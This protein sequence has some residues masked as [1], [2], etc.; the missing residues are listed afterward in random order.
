MS[1]NEELDF[2]LGAIVLA[3]VPF[4]MD[5]QYFAPETRSW[6]LVTRDQVCRLGRM[7]D[8]DPYEAY[9][10]WC[11]QE[12]AQRL[13]YFRLT[14]EEAEWINRHILHSGAVRGGSWWPWE[15]GYERDMLPHLS[16]D[17]GALLTA[18]SLSDSIMT[19]L[20]AGRAPDEEAGERLRFIFRQACCPS[21]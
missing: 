2:N 16:D 13:P 6:Y 3:P 19:A 21:V 14:E 5:Y 10:L 11:A 15:P 17:T 20:R 18:M 12:P 1:R 8:S 7:I 4:G 9:S